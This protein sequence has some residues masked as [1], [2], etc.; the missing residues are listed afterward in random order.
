MIISAMARPHGLQHSPCWMARS[1]GVACKNTDYPRVHHVPERRGVRR[2]GGKGHPRHSRQL[3][4]PQ[5][6]QSQAMAGRQSALGL[7]RHANICVL[8]QHRRGL[9]FHHHPKRI[10]RGVFKSVAELKDVIRRTIRD[11]NGHAKPFVGT[12]T[13]KKI[14]ANS[15]ACLYLLYETVHEKAEHASG[16]RCIESAT[17]AGPMRALS[18]VLAQGFTA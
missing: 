17:A 5:A 2:S 1:W 6:P 15:I 13:A 10:R 18:L 7:P 11:H 4:H 3:R 9:L 16:V 8:A 12:Q 14:S